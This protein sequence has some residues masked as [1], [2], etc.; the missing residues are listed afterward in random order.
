MAII[1][2]GIILRIGTIMVITLAPYQ[3]GNS[4][5]PDPS[6]AILRLSRV[7]PSKFAVGRSPSEARKKVAL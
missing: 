7:F 3:E 4:L 6:E 1:P 5:G 2:M